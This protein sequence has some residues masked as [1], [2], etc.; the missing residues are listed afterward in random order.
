MLSR[1]ALFKRL[2]AGLAGITV[3]P[4]IPGQW[5]VKASTKKVV[6]EPFWIQ[7]IRHSRVTSEAYTRSLKTL[8]YA[9]H[10]PNPDAELVI[11]RDQS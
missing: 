6:F 1:R 10:I 4:F 8:T 7:T 9:V 5:V 11:E 3:A 2:A